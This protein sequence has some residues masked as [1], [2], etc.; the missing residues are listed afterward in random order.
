VCPL[1]EESAVSDLTAAEARA[2]QLRSRFGEGV[3]LVHG[4][5]P[6]EARDAAM[7]DFIAGRAQLLVATTV[8]EVGVDVPEA[9]IIVIERAETFG[10]AQL[11]QLRGRVGRG[12]A[13]STCLLLYGPLGATARARLTTL[14]DTE[15]GFAIAETDLKLRGPGDLLGAQQSGLPRFAIADLERHGELM[16]IAQDDAR[17]ALARDPA[18]E[19]ARGRALRVLLWLHERDAALGYLAAG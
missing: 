18:L 17:L 2:A 9:S 8:I 13:A 11:H 6:A 15:D 14:R 19:G 3:R 1:V 7:A 10:L 12:A 5:M 4:Q 16:R